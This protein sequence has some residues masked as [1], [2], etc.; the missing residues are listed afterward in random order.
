MWRSGR[1]TENQNEN[2]LACADAGAVN[3]AGDKIEQETESSRSLG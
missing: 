2:S 1:E 3:R